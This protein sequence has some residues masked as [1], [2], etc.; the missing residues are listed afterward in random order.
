M[1]PKKQKKDSIMKFP[2]ETFNK[3]PTWIPILILGLLCLIVYSASGPD[4]KQVF[5]RETAEEILEQAEV[6]LLDP[7]MGGAR[8]FEIRV[9]NCFTND[10]MLSA[11][12]LGPA[13]AGCNGCRMSG[14]QATWQITPQ[15]Q[16]AWL[17]QGE[18]SK[19][20]F[21]ATVKERQHHH[22]DP[23][24]NLEF[25]GLTNN[26]V[27]IRRTIKIRPWQTATCYETATPPQID[28]VLDEAVWSEAPVFSAFWTPEG[29]HQAEHPTEVRMAYDGNNLYFAF[30][31]YV[32][33]ISRLKPSAAD[34][35]GSVFNAE[36][37]EIFLDTNLDRRHYYHWGINA[38]A[39]VDDAKCV[40]NE[41]HS[42]AHDRKWSGS[43]NCRAGREDHAWTLEVA[44]PWNTI[45]M[46][47]PQKGTQLGLQF[48][49]NTAGDSNKVE[50]T[51]WSPTYALNHEPNQFGILVIK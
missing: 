48:V 17:R 1:T 37:L 36:S 9:Q 24:V 34:R 50:T 42:Y 45:E 23:E 47:A 51:Q 30:R 21:I 33:D 2:G 40:W 26:P 35:D 20:L 22:Q 44:I 12:A 49:R 19:M 41:N 14:R 4:G 27:S 6:V 46:K 11:T 28:G 31:C 39:V 13:D 15:T 43:Q 38:N 16:S 25:V 29:H 18:K 7:T 5:S 8:R 32:T 10:V 3:T